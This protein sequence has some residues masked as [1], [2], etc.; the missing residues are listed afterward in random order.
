MACPRC[1]REPIEISVLLL[2]DADGGVVG[3]VPVKDLRLASCVPCGQVAWEVIRQ[4]R[5]M[6]MS[7]NDHRTGRT[8]WERIEVHHA[9]G[10]IVSFNVEEILQD[11][12]QPRW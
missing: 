5:G 10:S 2:V 9:D 12:P 1:D 8:K 6:L 7:V 11:K 3:R 4:N